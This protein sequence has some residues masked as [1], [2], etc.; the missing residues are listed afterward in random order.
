MKMAGVDSLTK[1]GTFLPQPEFHATTI[2]SKKIAKKLLTAV[3][4]IEEKNSGF[5]VRRLS[6]EIRLR[7]ILK[8]PIKE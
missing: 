8:Y 2:H 6:K 5:L 3:N 7:N 1:N 4:R